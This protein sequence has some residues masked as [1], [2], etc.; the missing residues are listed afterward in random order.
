MYCCFS[1]D[2]ESFGFVFV[3]FGLVLI[4][5]FKIVFSISNVTQ[6]WT[7]SGHLFPKSCHFFHLSK[8]GRGD[9]LKVASCAPGSYGNGVISP[10]VNS[11][12]NISEKVEL[13]AS[14]RHIERFWKSRIPIYYS[15]VKEKLW[16]RRRRRNNGNCK[17]YAFQA[18]AKN[19]DF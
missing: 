14:F 10:Y 4:D 6:R 2:K 15:K 3:S 13:V 8:K 12:M 17:A 5:A 11:Y 1:A 18:K 9:E 16:K 19:D 7:Q